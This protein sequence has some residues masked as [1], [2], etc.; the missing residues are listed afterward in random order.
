M[1]VKV[2][3]DTFVKVVAPNPNYTFDP[4]NWPEVTTVDHILVIPPGP[5]NRS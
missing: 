3:P 5:R 1:N 4:K 2:A